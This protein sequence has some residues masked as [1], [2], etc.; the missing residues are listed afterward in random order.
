MTLMAYMMSHYYLLM[1]HIEY[2][3]VP[4]A[5]SIFQ[6]LQSPFCC[7]MN[8]LSS[9]NKWVENGSGIRMDYVLLSGWIIIISSNPDLD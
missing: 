7:V 8:I 2:K 5:F 6:I 3:T 4:I 9:F 1:T